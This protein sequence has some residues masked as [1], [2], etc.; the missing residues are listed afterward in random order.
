MGYTGMCHCEGY[1]FQAVYSGI[2]YTNERVCN[3]NRTEWSPIR[4]VIIRVTLE[5]DLQSELDN[6]KFCYQLIITLTKFGAFY[7]TGKLPTYPSPKPT[8]P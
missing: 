8:L 6:T 1:G 7:L 3:S 2:G 5:S 4:C